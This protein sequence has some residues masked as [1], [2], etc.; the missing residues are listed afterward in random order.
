LSDPAVLLVGGFGSPTTAEV[1]EGIDRSVFIW[2]QRL[3]V[4]E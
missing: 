3:K 1:S 4:L 2:P